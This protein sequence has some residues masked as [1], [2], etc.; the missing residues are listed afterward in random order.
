VHAATGT[1]LVD[2]PVFEYLGA[3]SEVATFLKPNQ[4]TLVDVVLRRRLN[5]NVFRLT[6][7][8]SYQKIDGKPSK[9]WIN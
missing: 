5:K 6:K 9:D 1:Q 4:T 2:Y 8:L 3:V 7:K